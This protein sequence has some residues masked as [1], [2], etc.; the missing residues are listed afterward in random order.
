M[1]S[2]QTEGI[3]LKEYNYDEADKIFVIFTRDLGRVSCFA[4]SVRKSKSRM[5][6][7]LQLFTHSKL[8]LHKGKSMYT[9]I[10]GEVIDSHPELKSDLLSY[11][12]ANYFAE[13]LNSLLPE[14]E[15]NE[16]IFL[17]TA[18]ILQ[19]TG[20]IPNSQLSSMY[21]L[22]LL[23][24]TGFLPELFRCI[25]CRKTLAAAASFYPAKGGFLCQA[26]RNSGQVEAN[27]ISLG[28]LK[29]AQLMLTRDIP[30]AGRLKMSLAQQDRV[31]ELLN[32]YLESV[33]ERKLHSRD[34]IKDIR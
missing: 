27:L 13:I 17:L 18:A 9:V 22:K 28:T 26:C 20:T 7:F 5:R 33:L 24:L 12:Y 29:A 1:R 16:N 14:E 8:H 4:K 15:A 25:D 3:V 30:I 11:G 34:F 6:G 2:I 23:G 21:L 10:G 19:L 31:E 32:T